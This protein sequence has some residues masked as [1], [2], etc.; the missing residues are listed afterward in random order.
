MTARPSTPQTTT[1][2]TFSSLTAISP[3]DGR[4]RSKAA[5]IDRF[6]VLHAHAKGDGKRVPRQL[7]TD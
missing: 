2:L 5:K 7:K 1:S 4:Y 3:I 6:Y